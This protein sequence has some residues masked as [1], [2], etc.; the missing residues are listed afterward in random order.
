LFDDAAKCS[1]A[2]RRV[3]TRIVQTGQLHV[4]HLPCVP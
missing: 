1:I 2:N 3:R 4:P